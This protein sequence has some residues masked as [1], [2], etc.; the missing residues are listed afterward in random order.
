M[1]Q[2]KYRGWPA[3]AGPL[4]RRMAEV[5]LPEDVVRE[6]RIVVPVPTTRERLRERGY[7][8]AERL[9]AAYAFR[10]GRRLVPALERAGSR[11]SQTILQPA[12]RG[13]N[14]A[15]AFRI[16]EVAGSAVRGEHVL[17]VDD[18]LTTGATVVEC[19]RTL[20][21]AGARCA[22]VITFARA[23]SIRRAPGT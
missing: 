17:L 11:R 4:A 21:T 18:V 12:A 14:V 20:V 3:L 13:A 9:A 1:H 16:S 6:A 8:Q 5:P 7:N 10:T 22:S 15:G 2:L 19:A 23:W